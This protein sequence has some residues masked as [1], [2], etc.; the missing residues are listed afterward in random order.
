MSIYWNQKIVKAVRNIIFV[1]LAAFFLLALSTYIFSFIKD[2]IIV[3]K[4]SVKNNLFIPQLLEPTIKDGVETFNLTL[5]KGS[6]EFIKGKNTNTWG[7]NGNY[8]GPTIHMYTGK[9]VLMLV[10]N[11][12]GTITTMHWHGMLLPAIM[13]GVYQIIKPNTTWKPT[14]TV[15]NQAA[16]LWYHP[17]LMGYTG[18]QVMKGLSGMIIIDDNNSHSLN[19]PKHYGVDDI[20]VIVQDRRFDKNGQFI[21]KNKN[22][23]SG[24]K[25]FY[26]NKILVNG[27]YQP[28]KDVPRGW[29]RLRL[30]NASNARRYNFGFSDNRSFYQIASDGGFLNAPVKE[31]RLMLAPA[32][33]AEILVDMRNG[34]PVS[35]MSY[36]IPE[37]VSNQSIMGDIEKT[38]M[39]FYTNIFSNNTDMGQKFQLLELRPDASVGLTTRIPKHLNTIGQISA[40]NTVRTR[41]FILSSDN[42]INGKRMD[43]SRIDAV[44]YKDD[45]EIW[46]IINTDSMYH[47]FHVHNTQ[48]QIL[49]ING[50]KPPKYEQGFKDT[51]LVNPGD[52]VRIIVQ[53]KY[54]TDP[55]HPY[56]FHCHILE[57][58]DM[59]MMGQFV[60]VD[61]NT[62]IKDIYV[63]K[64][65][66]NEYSGSMSMYK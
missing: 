64:N 5:Q 50:E 22:P 24:M 9:K 47:S 25:E 32:E 34:L 10:H 65:Y 42:T 66:V 19:I 35:L 3:N 16:T 30:L 44:V 21:Y 33:R 28:Y 55:H 27:T 45:R 12:L 8:L 58:E 40:A 15:K 57:H 23:M 46:K 36:A 54:Y 7:I 62:N 1:I 43:P 51:I 53:F 11:K 37:V 26:G 6:K 31:T 49:D 52:T 41:T 20:P 18:E 38:L 39:N 17:H 56:M 59:G 2:Q 13:D 29:I 60:V 61:K 63:D 48:F 4:S 14:W